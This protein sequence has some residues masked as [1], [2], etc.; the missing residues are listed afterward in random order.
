MNK[1][2]YKKAFL[3]AVAAVTVLLAG[4]AS[5]GEL[6]IHNTTP[7]CIRVYADGQTDMWADQWRSFGWKQPGRWF[8]VSIFRYGCGGAAVEN[9]WVQMPLNNEKLVWQVYSIYH[10]LNKWN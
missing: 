8:M 4:S 3:G 2:I 6:V 7:A 10:I 5:A 9:K 1:S